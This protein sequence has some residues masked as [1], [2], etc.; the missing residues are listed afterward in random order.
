[1]VI[2]KGTIYLT[3]VLLHIGDPGVSHPQSQVFTEVKY[4]VPINNEF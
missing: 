1:M 4:I 2:N 3:S